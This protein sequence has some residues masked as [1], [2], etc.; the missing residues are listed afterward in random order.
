[1]KGKLFGMVA[2]VLVLAGVFVA[3]SWTA[4][5]ADAEEPLLPIVHVHSG[6]HQA[7]AP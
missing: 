1:M 3:G 6:H 2:A 4:A 7:L 5:T